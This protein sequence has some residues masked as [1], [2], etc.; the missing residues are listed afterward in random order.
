[1]AKGL[2]AQEIAAKWQSNASSASGNY[3]KGIGRVQQNPMA[4]AAQNLGKAKQNYIES[5]DSGRM[6]AK[7][8]GVTMESWK[9]AAATKGQ[10]NYSTGI[11][12]GA[13]KMLQ[14]QIKWTPIR[15]SIAA[16]VNAMPSNTFAERKARAMAM[17]DGMHNAKM[18]GQ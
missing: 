1:M 12:A 2:T 14:A 17:M 9:Q 7:L 4:K 13:S 8:N 15:D 18:G 6:A 16:G 5:I 10:S 3:A 11:A